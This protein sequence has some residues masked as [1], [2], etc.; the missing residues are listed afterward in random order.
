MFSVKVK[1]MQVVG[2]VKQ[3][4]SP[5]T[6]EV[7]TFETALKAVDMQ[8][9]ARIARIASFAL[10][11]TCFSTAGVILELNITLWP[12]SVGIAAIGLVALGVFWLINRNDQRYVDGLTCDV[13]KTL[14]KQELKTFFTT[15]RGEEKADA[16]RLKEI[17]LVLG[18]SLFNE[19]VL[20]RRR[21][22]AEQQNQGES[23]MGACQRLQLFL[24][25][26]LNH[27]FEDPARFGNTARRFHIEIN[28]DGKD[29]GT[30]DFELKE[31]IEAESS[32]EEVKVEE[33]VAKSD[34]V[35]SDLALEE[36]PAA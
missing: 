17:D 10:A 5:K 20:I 36:K 28:W 9:A 14:V 21:W 23:F 22:I 8:R 32:E 3:L 15:P 13:R 1:N 2:F 33:A 6:P 7:Y 24:P 19:D 35:G 25:L 18:Y 4:F 12:V 27:E 34:E 31:L 30:F 29:I 11:Y 26:K 16:Q